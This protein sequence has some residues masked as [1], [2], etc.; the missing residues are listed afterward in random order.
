MELLLFIVLMKCYIIFKHRTTYIYNILELIRED[1]IAMKTLL[2]V[3]LKACLS[4]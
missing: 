4:I 2:V 3:I 1:V